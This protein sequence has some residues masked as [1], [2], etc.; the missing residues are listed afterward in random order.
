MPH[1]PNSPRTP[2][3]TSPRAPLLGLTGGTLVAAYPAPPGPPRRRRA[4]RR[5]GPYARLF[6]APG[7]LAFTVPNVVAR[8]PMGMFGVSAVIMITAHHDSYALAGSV[9]AAGLLASAVAGPLVAR[10][11][12]RHGQARVVVPAAAV[13]AAGHLSLVACLLLGAPV[14]AYYGCALLTAAQPNTGGL[15]RARWAHLYGQDSQEH[16]AARHAAN[17]FEQAVDELCFLGGPVLATLLCTRLFPEAGTLTA[18]ALLLG[19]MVAFAARRG[20][21]PP[22]RPPAPGTARPGRISGLGALLV[23]FGCTGVVFGAMEVVTIAFADERGQ[24]AWAGLVL[25]A[26]A[27]GS[28]AAGLAFGLVRF[29]GSVR[30]RFTACVAAM[31]VLM[32]VP[33][34]ASRA[35]ELAWLAPALLVAGMATA[36]TMVTGMTL[37]Q[38]LA[39]VGR[40]NEGMTLAVTALLGGVALGSAAGG[41]AVDTLDAAAT[42][43]WLPAGAAALAA[44]VAATAVRTG[45]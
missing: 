32:A 14:W 30:A 28:A 35:G 13:C 23:A 12:D 45:R 25:S 29:T 18:T 34:A 33:L 4:R 6:A 16:T 20:T 17:S 41:W 11:V 43:Y 39:P 27:A 44:A 26:Q 19:G 2:P 10:L 8:L 42:G 38:R 1:S 15:S 7:A 9:V 24:R 31:A 36:P 3:H 21:E 5:P 22:P 37:V 40:L